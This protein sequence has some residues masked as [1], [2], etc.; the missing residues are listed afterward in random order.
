MQDTIQYELISA[1][2][3]IVGKYDKDK[4]DI[5][6][7]NWKFQPL[8]FEAT[9]GWSITSKLI[10]NTMSQILGSKCNIN[11]DIIRKSITNEVSCTLIRNI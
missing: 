10:I 8:S 4:N 1:E 3:A 5:I 7:E 9:G 2:K 11:H 6:D